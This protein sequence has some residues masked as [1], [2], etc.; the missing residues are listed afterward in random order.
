MKG[1]IFA[2]ASLLASVNAGVHKMPLKKVSISEQLAMANID[3]HARH[4]GQKYLGIR[5]DSHVEEMFK[6]AVHTDGDHT[7]P[8]SNFLN[9]QCKLK[10]QGFEAF[11]QLTPLQTFLRSLLVHLPRRSKSSSTL[12]APTCGF[13][14]PSVVPS[15]VSCT[16]NTTHL[17]HLHTR[18]TEL[19]LPSNTGLEA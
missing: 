1:A 4:L 6:S 15:P 13:H 5:P 14:P 12:E 10:H 16:Q 2:A 7:V 17:H 8:V 11:S 18:A 3:T 9:A 19:S